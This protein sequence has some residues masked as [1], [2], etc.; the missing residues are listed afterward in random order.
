MPASRRDELDRL[1][2]YA[3][4]KGVENNAALRCITTDGVR[5]SKKLTLTKFVSDIDT[6]DVLR[7]V[8]C[9]IA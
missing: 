8:T 7:H 5:F 3:A 2:R 4:A 1:W 9:S 6:S